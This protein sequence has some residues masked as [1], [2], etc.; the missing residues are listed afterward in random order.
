MKKIDKDKLALTYGLFKFKLATKEE[1][2]SAMNLA[3][4]ATLFKKLIA[5]NF[6]TFYENLSS[7]DIGDWLMEHKEYGQTHD[8]YMRSGIIPVSQERDTIY[9]TA[10]SCGEKGNLDAAFVNSM[11][12]VCESYFYGMK[13]KLLERPLDLMNYEIEIRQID[14]ARL[15]INA[16]HILMCLYKEIPSDAFCLVAF[17]DEDLYNEST[18]IKPRNYITKPNK[19]I[20]REFCYGLSSLKNRVGVF[21]FARYD[22]L[23]HSRQ[24]LKS[25]TKEEKLIKYFFVL[26]KRAAKVIVKEIAHLFGLKNCIYFRCNMNGFNSMEEFDQR[27]FEIC[28]ICLRKLYTNII[29]R[30]SSFNYSLRVHN[31][32]LIYDRFIKLRDS[33]SETFTGIFDEE[34]S[35]Y[36]ARLES[37]KDEI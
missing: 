10:L 12:L 22:P 17:T 19:T 8:E 25:K 5:A 30:P 24:A 11:L 2:I 26:L 18:V 33:L 31:P 14:E 16:N 1:Q 20:T 23:F 37:L 3:G 6:D 28:P 35:W 36:N 9:L 34:I 27:P 21:S 29:I 15:Q 7:P 13:V 4:E 32:L